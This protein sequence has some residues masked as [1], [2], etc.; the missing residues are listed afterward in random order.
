M[1]DEKKDSVAEAKAK[2]DVERA[3][4]AAT[5]AEIR[6]RADP[7]TLVAEARETATD[8]ATHFAE[9]ASRLANQGI[10]TVKRR[11][12]VAG[13]AVGGVGLIAALFAWRGHSRRQAT[14]RMGAKLANRASI[15]ELLDPPANPSVSSA[16]PATMAFDT[17]TNATGYA[18]SAQQETDYAQEHDQSR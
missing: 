18:S 12:E 9:D 14:K 17:Q 5:I 7:R 1:K 6:R 11:P 16:S 2:V 15:A 4:V 8:R 10:E 13:A 3:R